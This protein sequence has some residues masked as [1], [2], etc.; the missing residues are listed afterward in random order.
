[1]NG[2]FLVDLQLPRTTKTE[3]KSK[4]GALYNCTSIRE[5]AKDVAI[6]LKSIYNIMTDIFVMK[7]VAA[8]QFSK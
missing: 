3:I 1:M 2:L 4:A 8:R 7:Y 6:F 5:F